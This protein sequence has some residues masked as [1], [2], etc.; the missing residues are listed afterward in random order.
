MRKSGSF[1]T[2]AH[3]KCILAGEHAVL[4]GHA[5]VVIPIPQKSLVLS[6]HYSKN[7]IRVTSQTTSNEI[8]LDLFL[9]A[10]VQG[11]K[12]THKKLD[13]IQGNFILENNIQIGAGIGFS[14][15]LCVVITRWFIWEHF[16]K[17]SQL[18]PFAHHLENLFHGQSSGVDIVGALATT[19]MHF[20]TVGGGD[21]HAIKQK[22]QPKLYLSYSGVS[23]MTETMVNQVKLLKEMDP[24]LAHSID[25]EMDESVL[26]IELAL[27]SNEKKGIIMFAHA[28][29]QAK[30]CFETWNLITPAL[31]QHIDK[32]YSLGALAVKPTGAGAGGYVLSLWENAPSS[33]SPIEFM[34]L[35]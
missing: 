23:K 30:H 3:G 9:N 6:Y 22:W 33:N 31:K 8:S 17:K 13:D 35:F 26:E 19:P 29:E 11:L 7:P 32:V 4:R 24:K 12:Y 34:P 28:L 14:A 25:D 15:A 5:A 16:L 18:F 1:C 2:R 20:E 10:L 21:I 27:Q